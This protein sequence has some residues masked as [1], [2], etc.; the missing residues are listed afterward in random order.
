MPTNKAMTKNLGRVFTLSWSLAEGGVGGME[1]FITGA[2]LSCF[3]NELKVWPL[4]LELSK[5]RTF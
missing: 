1:G 4:N 3:V 5:F 2:M